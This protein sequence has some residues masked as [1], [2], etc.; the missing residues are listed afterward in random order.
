MVTV[1]EGLGIK[2]YSPPIGQLIEDL[3]LVG[4]KCRRQ[5]GVTSDQSGVGARHA[6]C[7]CRRLPL[8]VTVQCKHQL[9]LLGHPLLYTNNLLPA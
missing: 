8:T 2:K 3:A 1:S 6:L 5:P 4:W 9:V 7:Q